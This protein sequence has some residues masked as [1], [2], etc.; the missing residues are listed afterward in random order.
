MS[1]FFLK[2]SIEYNSKTE[3][4]GTELIIRFINTVKNL[5]FIEKQIKE[6]IYLFLK[7]LST[8]L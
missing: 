6:Q 1:N 3:I 5:V 8:V 7:Q 2:M 4:T